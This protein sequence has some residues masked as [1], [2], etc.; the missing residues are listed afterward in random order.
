MHSSLDHPV[1]AL[2]CNPTPQSGGYK[3]GAAVAQ[4]HKLSRASNWCAKPKKITPNTPT[5]YYSILLPAKCCKLHLEC[6]YYC[7]L[8]HCHCSQSPWGSSTSLPAA[9]TGKRT[10]SDTK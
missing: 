1:G 7:H 5:N 3:R 6:L 4:N 9:N 10:A 2:Q 8:W